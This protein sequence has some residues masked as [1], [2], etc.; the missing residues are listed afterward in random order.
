[1]SQYL[2]RFTGSYSDDAEVEALGNEHTA[3]VTKLAET[4]EPNA[5]GSFGIDQLE[6]TFSAVVTGSQVGDHLENVR[7]A[8]EEAKAGLAAI[9]PEVSGGF[10]FTD[11]DGVVTTE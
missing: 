2:I 5:Q 6:K 7:T 1:M 9:D 11:D 3:M 4:I 10:T 8:F